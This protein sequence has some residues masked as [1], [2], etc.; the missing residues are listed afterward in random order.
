[1]KYSLQILN[2]AEIE[3]SDAINYYERKLIGLGQ[4]FLE[5]VERSLSLIAKTP[6]LYAIKKMP[7]RSCPLKGFPYLI[8]Y[9]IEGE[10]I[11]VYSIFNTA[12]DPAKWPWNRESN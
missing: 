5:S 8:F 4:R 10:V 7:F 3:I 1:M 6:E 12:Q 11:V 2:S 9:A